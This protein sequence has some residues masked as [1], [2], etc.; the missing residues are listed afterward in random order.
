MKRLPED[1]I[2][3]VFGDH[4]MTDSGEHG[5]ASPEETDSGLFIY[6]PKPIF[7]V[8]CVSSSNGGSGNSNSSSSSNSSSACGNSSS[9]CSSSSGTVVV[10][11]TVVGV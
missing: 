8:Q 6:S 3:F 11:V 10:V 2:L 1:A 5:G 7:P 9:S 4:G